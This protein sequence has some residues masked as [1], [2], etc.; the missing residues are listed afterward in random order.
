MGAVELMPTIGDDLKK[1]S[2]KLNSHEPTPPADLV[3]QSLHTWAGPADVLGM[4]TF[5][6]YEN[7]HDNSKRRAI[8]KLSR[9]NA[10]FS[11][12]TKHNKKTRYFK[13]LLC[14]CTGFISACMAM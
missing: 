12:L 7:L 4:T 9:P 10:T 6:K 13:S 1:V 11:R 14:T 3:H 2:T 8:Q 5:E